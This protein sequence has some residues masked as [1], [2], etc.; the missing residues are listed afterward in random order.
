M[1]GLALRGAVLVDLAEL[2]LELVDAA[3]DA[4]TVDLE[5]GLAGA[6]GAD[7]G[8]ARRHAAALLGQ[9]RALAAHAGQPVLEQ[10]QLDLGL[11]L[12]AV[13][14]LGEDVEDHRGAV[15]GG[16]PEQLL[17]VALLGRG[18]LVVEHHGVAVGLEGHLVQLLGLALAHVGGRIGGATALHDP[19]DLVGAGGVDQ[20][21]QLVEA[22]LGV[23]GGARAAA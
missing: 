23:L 22:G 3:L 1:L 16:A 15:D 2:G 12:L 9:R 17:E 14:V 18:Q 10:G 4:A 6:A 7:A 13:G 21:R 19:A 20:Q 8:P 5:L 11:A